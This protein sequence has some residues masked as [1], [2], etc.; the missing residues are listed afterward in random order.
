M[1]LA[2][3]ASCIAALLLVLAAIA[4]TPRVAR[5]FGAPADINSPF[6]A[7]V[8]QGSATASWSNGALILTSDTTASNN[9]EMLVESTALPSTPYTFIAYVDL[10]G[11]VP[12][13]GCSLGRASCRERV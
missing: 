2:K 8:N 13:G 5:S 4:F 1:K 10:M 3:L 7:W 12:A 6:W 11:P 9:L